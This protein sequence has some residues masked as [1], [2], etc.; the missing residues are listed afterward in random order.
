LAQEAYLGSGLPSAQLSST[1]DYKPFLLAM[2]MTGVLLGMGNPLLD[3]SNTVDEE[4][5][6]KYELKAG[7]AILAED[8]HQPLFKEM[9]EKP[10]TEYI[11]GGATQ[12]S[13]R[14]AQ[15]MLSK[16]G[17]TS[18]MGCVGDDD[19]AKKMKDACDKAGVNAA[20]MVDKDTVTGTCAVCIMDKER[21]LVTNLAAANNYKVDHLKENMSILE[22]AKVVYSAGFFITVCPDAIET[23]AKHCNETGK[24]YCMNLSAPFIVEVPPFKAVLT[25]TMPLIDVLFGNETEAAVFAKS[26]GWSETSV[27]EIAKKI[28][29]LP[30]EG[31]KPRKVVITQGADPTIV[32]IKGEV[33]EYPVIRLPK[34]KLVDTNGAGDAYVGGF[35]SGLVQDKDMTYCCSAGAYAASVIVQRSG[36]TF[37]AKP[38]FRPPAPLKKPRFTKV[39][40]ITPDMRGLNLIVKVV[41][42]S[43]V[44]EG[45][46]EA[47]CGDDKGIVTFRLRGE[48]AKVCTV[49]TT[50]RVQNARVNMFGGFIRV[51]VDKWGKL[52]PASEDTPGG[53]PEFEVSEANDISSVEY[54]L[55]EA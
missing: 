26:E 45:L 12:N 34:H 7:D 52:A 27:A 1:R 37:P 40:K 46:S 55:A 53:K 47:V 11:A 30:K 44:S 28:S 21:S 19:N 6:K 49:G 16:K 23:C 31:D 14:V 24:T 38:S 48:Q 22:T 20:Y 9:I 2:A 33:T 4:V 35:L 50:L 17:A 3:I 5:M 10:G 36:C 15:W 13:I 29:L 54:E 25:K 8:K 18:Y 42:V 39:D 32:A 51:E 41:K 43:E